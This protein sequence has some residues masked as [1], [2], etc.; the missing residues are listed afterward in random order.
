M[1]GNTELTCRV[2]EDLY[3]YLPDV[4]GFLNGYAPA[5]TFAIEDKIPLISCDYYLSPERPP[6]D[7]VADFHELAE[8]NQER[9]YFLPAHGNLSVDGRLRDV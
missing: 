8:I 4:Q 2:V 9:P 1:E 6:D 7:A 5:F 3:N